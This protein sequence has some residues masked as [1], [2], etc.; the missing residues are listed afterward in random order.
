[1][2]DARLRIVGTVVGQLRRRPIGRR[3]CQRTLVGTP[4]VPQN[5]RYGIASPSAGVLSSG[6]AVA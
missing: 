6:L 3:R 4:Y 2:T 5:V 1:M